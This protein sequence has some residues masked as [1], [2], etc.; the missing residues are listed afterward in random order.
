MQSPLESEL[1]FHI[2]AVNLP[3]PE[4]QFRFHKVRKWTFDFTWPSQMVAVEVEGG[5]YNRGA[6]V[7][8]RGFTEDAEKYNS[9]NLLGWTVYRVTGDMVHDGR[10]V[11]LIEQALKRQ[12]GCIQTIEKLRDC[13]STTWGRTPLSCQEVRGIA[14]ALAA[15]DLILEGRK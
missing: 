7:R 3:E 12:A 13:L 14:D 8:P 11:A 5:I 6:H 15:A 9:A 1:L 2:H 10:A 4:C